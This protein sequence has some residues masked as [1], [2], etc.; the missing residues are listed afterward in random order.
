MADPTPGVATSE[1]AVT[2]LAVV[3]SI[4]ASV[5]GVV[6]DTL[7]QLQAA[8]PGASHWTGPVLAVV[9]V[10]GTVLTALGYQ[11]TRASVKAAAHAAATAPAVTVEAAAANLAKS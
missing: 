9:G 7:P 11:V 3:L 8:V 10:V 4:L 2:K 1:Y 6:L 5:V